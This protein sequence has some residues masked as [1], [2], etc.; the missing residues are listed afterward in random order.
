MLE[1]TVMDE[2]ISDICGRPGLVLVARG[3]FT[4]TFVTYFIGEKK[5]GES[6]Y[7]ENFSR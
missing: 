6:F 2:N 3:I 5:S 7:G 1:A 4:G